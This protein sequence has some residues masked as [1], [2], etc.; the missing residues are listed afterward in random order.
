MNKAARCSIARTYGFN[1]GYGASV[2]ERACSCVGERGL[3]E[4]AVLKGRIICYDTPIADSIICH[5]SEVEVNT[6][7][8]RIEQLAAVVE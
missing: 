8:D 3:Y 2:I 1:N 6:L 5:L 7:L 4:L